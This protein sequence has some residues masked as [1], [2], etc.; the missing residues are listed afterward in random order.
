M[1]P[2]LYQ[3]FHLFI[4]FS[5]THS[6]ASRKDIDIIISVQRQVWQQNMLATLVTAKSFLE[7]RLVFVIRRCVWFQLSFPAS[8]SSMCWTVCLM[9]CVSILNG[10]RR[11]DLVSVSASFLLFE[12]SS[13]GGVYST[14][15]SAANRAFAWFSVI[16]LEVYKHPIIFLYWYFLWSCAVEVN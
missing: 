16:T 5:I 11:R 4:Y 12:T 7:K 14:N 10:G 6:S 15:V 3:V 13:P 1:W 9:F 2:L 8:S